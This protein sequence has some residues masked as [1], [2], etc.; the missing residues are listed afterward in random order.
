MQQVTATLRFFATRAYQR[1]TG[2]IVGVDID[3]TTVSKTIKTVA[4]AIAS[5]RAEVIKLPMRTERAEIT[6]GY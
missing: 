1:V 3:R 6:N 4:R 5:W 2:D